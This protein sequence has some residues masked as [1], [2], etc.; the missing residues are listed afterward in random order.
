MFG[1]TCTKLTA[2]QRRVQTIKRTAGSAFYVAAA[3]TVAA[4]VYA[5][6]HTWLGA[7]VG[8][9]TPLAFF[10]SLELLERVPAAGKAGV[11]RS[12]SIGVIA[13]IA[14]WG[15]YWH[16]VHVLHSAGV[17]DPVSLYGMPLT[18]DL[19]MVISRMAMHHKAPA[20]PAVRRKAQAPAKL[21]SV[22]SA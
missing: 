18:V 5:S 21:R 13:A 6:Q 17:H 19:L 10:I 8:L 7:A 16:L 12:I 3:A 15:S 4:N 1:K 2:A 9:W 14:G 22:K 20:R 11:A